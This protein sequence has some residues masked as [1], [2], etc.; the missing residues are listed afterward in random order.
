MQIWVRKNFLISNAESQCLRPDAVVIVASIRAL[1]HHGGSSKEDLSNENLEVLS[2]GIPNLLKHIENINGVFHLP[3]VVAI[4][5]FP[6][7]TDNEVI[8]FMINAVN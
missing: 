5:K 8:W 1:K 4:N 3:V 6:T 7:D 2:K